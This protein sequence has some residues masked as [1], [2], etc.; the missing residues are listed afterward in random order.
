MTKFKIYR[1]NGY[2]R[3]T[4]QIVEAYDWISLVQNYQ[5]SGDPIFRIEVFGG[6]EPEELK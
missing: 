2:G 6:T 4:V 3:V 5:Y 1:I